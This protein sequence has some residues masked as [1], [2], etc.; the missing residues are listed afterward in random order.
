MHFAVK[1]A[2]MF[3]KQAFFHFSRLIWPG[4]ILSSR[5]TTEAADDLINNI[6][7]AE[8]CVDKRLPVN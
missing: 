7:M 8:R 3:Q 4:E 5:A 1:E 6:K 2:Y